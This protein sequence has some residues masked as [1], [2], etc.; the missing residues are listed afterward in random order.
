MFRRLFHAAERMKGMW[1]NYMA[2]PLSLVLL[3]C[4]CGGSNTATNTENS[5]TAE[6][7]VEDESQLKNADVENS[8]ENAS[9]M[10]T[11]SENSTE[12]VSTSG[13]DTENSTQEDDSITIKEQTYGE[14]GE[15]SFR[16]WKSVKS[17]DSCL[18]IIC[19]ND[20]GWKAAWAFAY[21]IAT[22]KDGSEDSDYH[23]TVGSMCR[24]E[25]AVLFYSDTSGGMCMVDGEI[26]DAKE[27]IES[28]I[29][30][31][32]TIEDEYI[33][34]TG[35]L[36]DSYN[37]FLEKK[38][39][40]EPILLY[41]DDNVSISFSKVNENGVYF[42]VENKTKFN[43]T[44]QADSIAINGKSTNSI[45]MSDDVAPLSTGEIDARTSDFPDVDSVESIS[46]SLR[47]ICDDDSV[48]HYNVTFTETVEK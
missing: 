41:D 4:G 10:E 45:I 11:R 29:E 16:I 20:V 17:G 21:Y 23:F 24:E 22:L 2:I 26:V 14:N 15:L 34:Y 3:V 43:I 1:K 8:V 30:N 28:K 12:N 25:S 37:D 5:I 44:I 46:G 27:Y 13:A 39:E 33:E 7:A 48:G 6:K 9:Y 47:V 38:K 18:D 36:S 32:H 31:V 35:F 19:K 42:S 40:T